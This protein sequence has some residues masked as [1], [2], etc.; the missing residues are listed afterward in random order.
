MTEIGG[1]MILLGCNW[2]VFVIAGMVGRAALTE[3][4]P[5]QSFS[6]LLTFISHS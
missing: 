1:I 4:D 6:E 2:M 3:L 5:F